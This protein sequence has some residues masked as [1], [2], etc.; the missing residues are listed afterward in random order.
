LQNQAQHRDRLSHPNTNDALVP[1]ETTAHLQLVLEEHLG[2]M[3]QPYKRL[4]EAN[5]EQIPL[6]L[7]W[8]STH[9]I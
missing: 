2:P 1:H 9:A 6:Y 4:H 8:L 7:A 3:Q 5:V